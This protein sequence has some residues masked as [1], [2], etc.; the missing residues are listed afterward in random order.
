[1][2]FQCRFQ[3]L[4]KLSVLLQA[5]SFVCGLQHGK[6]LVAS[7]QAVGGPGNTLHCIGT[8]PAST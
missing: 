4:L 5:K 2:D 3:K 1:M 7:T 6:Y 8:G